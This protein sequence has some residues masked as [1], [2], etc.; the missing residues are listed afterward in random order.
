[1]AKLLAPGRANGAV[2]RGIQNHARTPATATG[3]DIGLHR[4]KQRQVGEAQVLV[5]DGSGKLLDGGQP[6]PLSPDPVQQEPGAIH[7]ISESGGRP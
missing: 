6:L 2:T 1:M 7:G 4:L 3:V 5:L